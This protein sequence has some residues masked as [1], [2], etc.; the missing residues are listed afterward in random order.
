MRKHLCSTNSQG[1][2]KL[3]VKVQFFSFTRKYGETEMIAKLPGDECKVADLISFLNAHLDKSFAEE[4][5]NSIAEN[6]RLQALIYVRN[7]NI[8]NLQGMDTV[9]RDGDTVKFLPVMWEG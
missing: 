6:P 9:I 3:E 7:E 5:G 1:G 8:L 4:I 2:I